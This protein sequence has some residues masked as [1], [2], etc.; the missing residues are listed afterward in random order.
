LSA[1]P[2]DEGT[3]D[4][5]LDEILKLGGFAAHHVDSLLSAVMAPARVLKEIPS[6]EGKPVVRAQEI[7]YG[8]EGRYLRSASI[9]RTPLP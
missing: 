9:T 4:R 7:Y 1:S 6:F 2:L 8:P 3:L 5:P